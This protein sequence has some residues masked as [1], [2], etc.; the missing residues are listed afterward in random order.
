M[1]MVVSTRQLGLD[2]RNSAGKDLY[3]WH[4]FDDV[5]TPEERQAK[6]Y[7][8]QKIRRAIKRR[9]KRKGVGRGK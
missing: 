6:H 5:I 4:Y 7:A 2:P 3:G 1:V 9:Q 8:K